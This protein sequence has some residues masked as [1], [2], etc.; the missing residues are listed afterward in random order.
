MGLWLCLVFVSQAA[1]DAGRQVLCGSIDTRASVPVAQP[2]SH[3]EVTIDLEPIL[4][5]LDDFSPVS[6]V[7]TTAREALTAKFERIQAE[8]FQHPVGQASRFCSPAAR[9]APTGADN[10]DR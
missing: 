3:I 5:E 2:D 8:C 7:S 4:A 6:E 9:T 10:A 1:V